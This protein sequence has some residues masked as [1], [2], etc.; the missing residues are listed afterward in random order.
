MHLAWQVL[1]VRWEHQVPRAN[2]E[3]PDHRGH[4]A[5]RDNRVHMG[6]LD[7]KDH[8]ERLALRVMR[9]L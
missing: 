3:T 9:V 2:R 1:R 4:Q 7:L 8:V 5:R 6:F